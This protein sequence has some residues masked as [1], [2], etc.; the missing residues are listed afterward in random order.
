MPKK[1]PRNKQRVPFSG[2]PRSAASLL[3]D[4]SRGRIHSP[5]GGQGLAEPGALLAGLRAALGPLGT[6]VLQA[7]V[8]DGSLVIYTGSAAWGGRLR[9][10]VTE[11]IAA[12]P[13]LSLPGVGP[14]TR[15]V[16]RIMPKDGYR[17]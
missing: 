12:R 1:P 16:V 6:H 15:V 17:R 9:L 2:S 8:R 14:D 5:P 10:M 11:H 13:A 7:R 4:I 3:A